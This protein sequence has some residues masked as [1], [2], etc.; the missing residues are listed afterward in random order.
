LA[1]AGTSQIKAAA[2]YNGAA[3]FFFLLGFTASSVVPL[4]LGTTSYKNSKEG[5]SRSP[6][7]PSA[8]KAA[9]QAILL[10]HPFDYAQDRL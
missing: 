2:L 3:A 4:L 9:L 8:A 6:N 10:R 7:I 5:L 1:E